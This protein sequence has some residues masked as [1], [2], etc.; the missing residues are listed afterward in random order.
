VGCLDRD[1]RPALLPRV[2]PATQGERYDPDAEAIYYC[3]NLGPDERETL[4]PEY[5]APIVEHA[6]CREEAI[7]TFE[8]ARG[9]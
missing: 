4:A 3:P 5:S 8:A 9:E 2:Q 6:D 7:A 1:G